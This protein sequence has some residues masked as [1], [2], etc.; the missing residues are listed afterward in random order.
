MRRDKERYGR[1]LAETVDIYFKANDLRPEL[2]A[3]KK[4]CSN[5]ISQQSTI[6]KVDGHTV[7][8]VDVYRVCRA[9]CI[10]NLY[11]AV[12]L[13]GQLPLATLPMAA[14]D[15]PRVEILLSLNEVRETARKLK[16][17]VGCIRCGSVCREATCYSL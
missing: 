2:R 14:G 15:L 4:L 1:G 17:S 7:S 16:G 11:T 13:N 5:F 3:L 6:Q 9:E 8:D 10:G 12:P